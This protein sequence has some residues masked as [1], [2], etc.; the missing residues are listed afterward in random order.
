[1]VRK[2]DNCVVVIWLSLCSRF[3]EMVVLDCEMFGMRVKY[4]I[5]LIVMVLVRFSLFLFLCCEV[6]VLV[7][8]MIRF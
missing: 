5:I 4:C 1:M 8:Y 7:Y 3:I 2:N 6:C